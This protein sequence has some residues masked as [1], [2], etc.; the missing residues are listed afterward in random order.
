MVWNDGVVRSTG[1]DFSALRPLHLRGSRASLPSFIHSA[2]TCSAATHAAAG[3]ALRSNDERRIQHPPTRLP[4][5]SSPLAS[6]LH[7]SSFRPHGCHPPRS[8][9][10]LFSAGPASACPAATHLAL[11]PLQARLPTALSPPSPLPARAAQVHRLPAGFPPPRSPA[12]LS[13]VYSTVEGPTVEGPFSPSGFR[14][15]GCRRPNPGSQLTLIQEPCHRPTPP[16]RTTNLSLSSQCCSQPSRQLILE[17]FLN[18]TN[19][20]T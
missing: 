10:L 19:S 13:L 12:R 8:R 14:P 18:Q 15:P 7:R 4:S 9:R 20:S 5:A 6:L 11:L 3:L 1:A 16:A 17:A 2:C